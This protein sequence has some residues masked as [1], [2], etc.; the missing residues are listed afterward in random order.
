MRR[1]LFGALV[2]LT[3]L[4]CSRHPTRE[5][6]EKQELDREQV[7]MMQKLLNAAA[8]R[9][10]EGGIRAADAAPTTEAP[11]PKPSAAPR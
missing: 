11:A 2:T 10:L 1:I 5:E 8:D 3:V 9:E 7:A 6:R 4:G